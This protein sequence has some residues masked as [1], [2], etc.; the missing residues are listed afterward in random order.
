MKK[1]LIACVLALPL[2]AMALGSDE[3]WTEVSVENADYLKG[4]TEV[5]AKKWQAA[6]DAFNRA[7]KSEP[8]NADI[9]NYLGYSYRNLDKL[10][11]SFRH[12]GEALRL[13]P[14]HRGANN[15]VGIAYLKSGKPEKAEEHLARL[16]K[17][18]GRSCAE[19]VDLQK[20]ITA[21][22]TNKTYAGS[23]Y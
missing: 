7:L 8:R 6:V 5:A 1:M 20:A 22:K 23:L 2:A 19:Y 3:A 4:K 10:D 16:E 14:N 13:E 12:Y 9:H 17:I 11:L 21:Y 15:Y 18:C